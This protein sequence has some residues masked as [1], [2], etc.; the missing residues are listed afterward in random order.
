MQ[1]NVPCIILTHLTINPPQKGAK[2]STAS[3]DTSSEPTDGCNDSRMIQL[4]LF[5]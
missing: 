4:F 3:T 1:K 2:T 5:L